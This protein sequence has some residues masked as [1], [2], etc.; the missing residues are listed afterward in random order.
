MLEILRR[1]KL[2]RLFAGMLAVLICLPLAACGF[3]GGNA[4][5]AGQERIVAVNTAN[6][7]RGDIRTELSFLGQV[8]ASTQIAVMSRVQG[9]VDQV[10]VRT[11]DYVNAGDV[12][13]TMDEIDLQNSINSLA[14]Q[15]ATAE[16]AVNSARTGVALAGGSAVQGQILQSETAMMQAQAGVEQAELAIDQR[17]LAVRQAQNAHD[18]VVKNLEN[19]TLL[20]EY[21]DISQAQFDQAQAAANNAAI[22]LEQAQSAYDMAVV[23]LG[24][25]T[26]ALAQAQESNRIVS[27][28]VRSESIRRAQDGLAQAEAQR[29]SLAVNLEAAQERLNDAS[30]TAPISG[31]I[32]S[33]N[34]EP[35]AMLLPN[36][37]PI[38]IV[39][40]DNV[41]VQAN[42]TETIINR[43]TLGQQVRVNVSAASELP[44]TGEV[45][46][47]SP[48]ANDMTAAF[49]IEIE[50]DNSD[51]LLR[52]GMFA[53][54]FFVREEAINSIIVPRSAVLLVEG[55]PV[56]FI[57]V[58]EHAVKRDVS[59]GIDNGF[60][61]EITG[62]LN[63]GEQLI[64]TGQTFVRDGSPIYIVE[65]RGEAS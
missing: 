9:K 29:D 34:V 53:E 54:A 16:A 20:L 8:R 31:T 39:S 15:L 49:S 26:N 21:G 33:R 2:V 51:G 25:A 32:S 58:G 59:L 35:Q 50:I 63:E 23:S 5:E 44:F 12:L 42:V 10:M 7:Q 43:I 19:M 55:S 56:V 60:E 13:F 40:T 6:V 57:A 65:S 27:N 62:G 18:D 4:S 3:G 47:V 61:V 46:V 11:G 14:A 64:V 41:R 48:A 17:T 37:A 28:N 1:R 45:T 52:P 36:V 30:I 38:T 22:A 24:Q